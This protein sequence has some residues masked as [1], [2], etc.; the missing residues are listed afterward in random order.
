MG[1]ACTLHTFVKVTEQCVGI[2][3]VLPPSESWDQIV[4]HSNK[5]CLLLAGLMEPI[6]NEQTEN[7]NDQ[8]K[9]GRDEL[10]FESNLD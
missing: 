5:H 2:A 8:G 6:L 9:V 3:S 1:D 4:G 7:C 10:L